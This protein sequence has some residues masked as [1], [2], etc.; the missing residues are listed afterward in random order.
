MPGRCLPGR[1]GAPGP[2]R[3]DPVHPV[4]VGGDLARREE[5][6]SIFR[7]TL[8]DGGGL[9]SP[10]LDERHGPAYPRPM[11]PIALLLLLA[12]SSVG[13]EEPD[14]PAVRSCEPPCR[15][16]Y[17]CRDGECVSECNPLCPSGYLC[18]DRECVA[19]P[20]APRVSAPPGQG[21]DKGRSKDLSRNSFVGLGGGMRAT[22]KGAGAMDLPSAAFVGIDTGTRYLGG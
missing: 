17:Y 15:K 13:A 4:G 18:Q 22:V 10:W 11:R 20:N 16:G 2:P 6:S 8:A 14:A 19:D 5:R 9:A 3:S 1:H 21:E 7:T 12:A